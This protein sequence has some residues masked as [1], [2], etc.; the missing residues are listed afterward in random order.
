MK[1]IASDEDHYMTWPPER[2][3]R[4]DRF[5]DILLKYPIELG[6]FSYEADQRTRLFGWVYRVAVH[7]VF[8]N[9]ET[10]CE[11]NGAMAHVYFA[12]TQEISDLGI[13]RYFRKVRWPETLGGY[14]VERARL[15]PALQAAEIVA[16]GMRRLM[17][18]GGITHSF[19]RLW[20]ESRQRG[21]EFRSWPP[22]PLDA[23][24]ALGRSPRLLDLLS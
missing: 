14:S 16:R 8:I 5:V 12:Q 23:A 2:Q 17:Q 18:D 9:A 20:R 24:A 4:L 11:A 15:N 3:Q 10:L 1:D 22:E 19:G 21:V 6:A 13:G 7:R